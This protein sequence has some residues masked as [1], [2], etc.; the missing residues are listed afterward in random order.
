MTL[1]QNSSPPKGMTWPRA[2]P[3]LVICVALDITRAFFSL[4][5]LLGPVVAAVTCVSQS[6]SVGD[7]L[8]TEVTT[9]LCTAAAAGVGV[10]LS[11]EL[12]AFGTFVAMFL[13]LAG[14]MGVW[15]FLALNNPRIFKEN[16]TTLIR[17]IATLGIMELPFVG[18][19]PAL[20]FN[21]LHLY[22]V[23]IR[24][25]KKRLVEWKQQESARIAQERR[26]IRMSELMLQQSLTDQQAELEF[27]R[28]EQEREAAER[29]AEE[30][31]IAKEKADEER[32]EEERIAKEKA[33]AERKAEEA[34][35]I[36]AE[37]E[38]RA[39][40][41]EEEQELAESAQHRYHE[42]LGVAK[43]MVR[44]VK[45]ARARRRNKLQQHTIRESYEIPVNSGE[46]KE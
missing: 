31:R 9:A 3:I 26:A 10:V 41:R 23:Q 37:Q 19:L 28:E 44:V 4:F 13:G 40:A 2:T 8:G 45:L 30:E 1:R 39:R 18:S 14:W 6:G 15:L 34:A 43:D 21:T 33:D 29:K 22:R 12:F 27:E 36:R 17:L 25:D 24:H 16:A 5:W 35:R 38:E 42:E 20:T 32:K 7:F 46:S 11:P